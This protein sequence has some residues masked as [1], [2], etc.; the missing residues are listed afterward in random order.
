MP[1]HSSALIF[2][3]LEADM[4]LPTSSPWLSRLRCR[5]LLLASN[6]GRATNQYLPTSS[7]LFVF[8][9]ATHLHDW[10]PTENWTPE[11]D[12]KPSHCRQSSPNTDACG[13]ALTDARSN[14]AHG[15]AP[16]TL[17]VASWGGGRSDH[18][19]KSTNEPCVGHGATHTAITNGDCIGVARSTLPFAN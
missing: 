19:C 7:C 13:V 12:V 15:D 6:L 4:R 18:R 14:L 9:V 16:D 11:F 8:F 17:S 1:E 5:K 3:D 10:R 2:A